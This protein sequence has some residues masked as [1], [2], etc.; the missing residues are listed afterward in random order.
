[1]SLEVKNFGQKQS[2]KIFLDAQSKM[3]FS[4]RNTSNDNNSSSNSSWRS[5]IT[6]GLNFE[7]I[8]LRGMSTNTCNKL[9]HQNGH[10]FKDKTFY[11]IDLFQNKYFFRHRLLGKLFIIQ[12]DTLIL[13]YFYFKYFQQSWNRYAVGWFH[14]YMFHLVGQL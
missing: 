3:L 6:K 7:P 9:N 12:S 4:I 11:L 1:M 10:C 14:N 13:S 8:K 5:E 2:L